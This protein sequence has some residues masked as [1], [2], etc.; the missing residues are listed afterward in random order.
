MNEHVQFTAWRR[1][2]FVGW[3]YKWLSL[4]LIFIVC[5]F[6]SVP[7]FSFGA[8]ASC[9]SSFEC[10]KIESAN[11]TYFSSFPSIFVCFCSSSVHQLFLY[12]AFLLEN[13]VCWIKFS[14]KNYNS[15]SDV[16]VEED[17]CLPQKEAWG[18]FHW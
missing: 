8:N 2:H 14:I 3:I 17:F 1:W 18:P 9:V 11:H 16:E 4:M 5:S 10:S 7:T 6:I 12:I 13:V 15:V